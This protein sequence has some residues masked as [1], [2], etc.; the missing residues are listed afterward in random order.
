M[1]PAAPREMHVLGGCR[2]GLVLGERIGV[3]RWVR[4]LGLRLRDRVRVG[5][6]GAEDG[7]CRPGR[8]S[9]ADIGKSHLALAAVTASETLFAEMIVARIL[10]ATGAN[11]SGFLSTNTAHERH[12]G[13]YFFLTVLGAAWVTMARQ[14]CASWSITSN[15]RSLWAASSTMYL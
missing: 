6:N 4:R 13:D 1:Q 9:A 2:A 12:E 7:A 8:H 14:R 11:S 15:S 3:G 10:G 5:R